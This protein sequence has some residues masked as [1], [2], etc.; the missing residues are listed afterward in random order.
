M[1]KLLVISVLLFAPIS[2]A[3][4]IY[5]TYRLMTV[6]AIIPVQDKSA[7]MIS[8][9]SKLVE[10]PSNEA[11]TVVVIDD[12]EIL[13]KQGLFPMSESGDVIL[14]YKG[15]KKAILYRP[16]TNK[17]IDISVI[18]ITD[19]QPPETATP[20]PTPPEVTPSPAPESVIVPPTPIPTP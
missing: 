3:L 19:E 8:A 13:K 18:N 1:K 15:E 16:I 12:P 17:I 14:V 4:N 11:P 6:P 9:I 7:E 10:L 20:T 2:G 5:L